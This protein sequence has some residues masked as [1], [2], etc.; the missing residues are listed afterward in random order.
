MRFRILP[1]L[2][3]LALTLGFL[4][5]AASGVEPDDSAV[6]ATLPFL[7]APEPNRILVD[8]APEGSRPFPMMLDTGA[9]FSGMAPQLAKKLRVKQDPYLR[10]TSLGRSLQLHVDTPSSDADSETGSEYALLGGNF[11]SHY[12]V[13]LDFEKRRVRFLDPEKFSVPEEDGDALVVGMFRPDNRPLIDIRLGQ[14]VVRVRVDTGMPYPMRFSGRAIGGIDVEEQSLATVQS[15]MSAVGNDARIVEVP[16][17]RIGSLEFTREPAWF[18]PK[19]NFNSGS[20]DESILGYDFLS[21]FLVRIDYA[22]RRLWL[23]PR[24]HAVKTF[25][26][27]DYALSKQAGALVGRFGDSVR[28]IGVWR[29]SPAAALGLFPG[30]RIPASRSADA[31]GAL[32]SVI[33]AENLEVA[34]EVGGRT[35]TV[36]LPSFE[37]PFPLDGTPS[38]D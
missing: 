23:K 21:R 3:V 16:S 37:D 32:R 17:I 34:R 4:P 18:T 19:G 12:V 15:K 28:V 6:V 26:G 8:L 10:S 25:L 36:T 24:K 30:D 20:V 9:S 2:G 29:D 22:N 35:K 1:W 11:L 38:P 27:A 7:D 5:D 33:A 13:E 14:R 31:N